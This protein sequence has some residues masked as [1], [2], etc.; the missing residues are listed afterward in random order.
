M[1]YY[2]YT[3]HYVTLPAESRDL[4]KAVD[5]QDFEL[6]TQ[7]LAFIHCQTLGQ[8]PLNIRKAEATLISN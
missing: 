6:R 7:K 3:T 2:H 4:F 5:Y 8:T 1:Y